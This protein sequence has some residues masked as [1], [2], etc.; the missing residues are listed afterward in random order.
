M[1]WTADTN[2]G[3]TT[4]T[5]WESLGS[6]YRAANVTVESADPVS[7]LSYYKTLINLRADNP[8]L[9]SGTLTVLST[10]NSGI[11]AILRA[12][13]NT[14]F[15]IL[16]NLSGNP[17][18]SYALNGGDSVFANGTFH[19]R[20]ILGSGTF[21]NGIVSNSKLSNYQPLPT[22][23]ANGEYIIELYQ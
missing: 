2:A 8:I 23:P 6:N 12:E 18:S 7:L 16:A 10:G 11:Y 17:I 21:S 5:A 13:N 20:S 14:V 9:R 3:F 1:Q 19:A 4:G 15:L 22:L